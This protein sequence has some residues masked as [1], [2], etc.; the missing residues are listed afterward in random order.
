M[1]AGILQ[2]RISSTRLYSKILKKI[3]N[4][5]LLE[6]YVNRIKKSKCLDKIIIAT[7]IKEE[8]DIIKDIS[9]SLNIDCFRGSENDLIDRYYKC[10]KKYNVKII[11]R[12]C[13]DDPFV[14]YNI[15]DRS[16]KIFQKNKNEMAIV[17]NHLYPSYPEGLDIDVF[18]FKG[19]EKCWIESQLESEREHVFPYFFYSGKFKI[20]NFKQKINYSHL[21]WTLDYEEDF[22]MTKKIYE[23]LYDK[24]PYFVQKDILELLE[25][26]PEIKNI[27][28]GIKHYEGIKKSFKKDGVNFE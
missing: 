26:Y 16:I 13:S 7:S 27:N 1:I 12:L 11:I 21:R 28:S 24:N 9:K 23:H 6:L 20:I 17:T 10:A 3:K 25:K 15:I 19:L 8:N 4:K 5:T 22:E 18:S 2:A 14:D